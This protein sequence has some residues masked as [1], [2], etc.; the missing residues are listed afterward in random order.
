M[1][2]LTLSATV[3]SGMI[4]DFD[5]D[6]NYCNNVWHGSWSPVFDFPHRWAHCSGEWYVKD[7]DHSY[8]QMYLCMHFLEKMLRLDPTRRVTAAH[9]LESPWIFQTDQ[10]LTDEGRRAVLWA[11]VETTSERMY[12]NFFN[13]LNAQLPRTNEYITKVSCPAKK[14]EPK[15]GYVEPNSAKEDDFKPDA[16]DLGEKTKAKSVNFA[17]PHLDS[18]S[19]EP[20]YKAATV[21]AHVEGKV[22]K[23]IEQLNK[24]IGSLWK[25]V[26][27]L[28]ETNTANLENFKPTNEGSQQ[29]EDHNELPDDKN[30]SLKAKE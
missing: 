8:D 16:T 20:E 4:R 7:F 24:E 9:L 27:G 6:L 3:Y 26:K 30:S 11:E 13:A 17:K 19:S 2:L 10:Y 15:T 22:T 29:L 18:C 14:A 12:Y 23:T 5:D 21:K 1:Q 25:E 28:M